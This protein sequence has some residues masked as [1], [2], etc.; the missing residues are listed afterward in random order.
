MTNVKKT[1]TDKS[2]K[3]LGYKGEQFV[4]DKLRTRGFELYKSNITHIG[5]E[6]DLVM[7]KYNPER[8]SLDIRIIE[9]KTRSSYEF[10]LENLGIAKK[11][12]LIRKYMFQ[13][14]SEI[15]AKFEILNHSWIHFD[16]ALVRSCDDS[17]IMY[18]YIKDINLLL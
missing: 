11:W 18:S 17:L 12:P 5:S 2:K 16:L 8:Y 6:I 14:K 13:I 4:L 15:D 3:A 10:D 9:V 1:K 7:Y